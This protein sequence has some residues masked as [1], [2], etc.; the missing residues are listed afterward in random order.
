MENQANRTRTFEKGPGRGIGRFILPG[1]ALAGLLFL[2]PKL[3]EALSVSW[4]YERGDRAFQQ[5]RYDEAEQYYRKMAAHGWENYFAYILVG[6]TCSYQRKFEEAL[7]EYKKAEALFPSY[8]KIHYKKGLVLQYMGRFREAVEAFTQ[9]IE[10]N[11]T[12][13]LAT[14]HR[15]ISM[16]SA[17]DLDE[18][19]RRYEIYLRSRKATPAELREAGEMFMRA[20]G[21]KNRA[22][23][24]RKED[25]IKALKYYDWCRQEG[26]EALYPDLEKSIQTIEQLLQ[27]F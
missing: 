22:Q 14:R 2:L 10:L 25:L 3:C 24:K 26:G 9:C 13:G 21:K 6:D 8:F 27:G 23:E 19:L 16:F 12:Y 20:Y 18:A 5:K 7:R 1:L 11:P 4:D 15:I 17:G